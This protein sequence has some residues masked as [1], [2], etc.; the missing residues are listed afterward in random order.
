MA[1]YALMLAAGLA[2]V[3]LAAAACG[4][5]SSDPLAL[6]GYLSQVE[7]LDDQAEQ[8]QNQLEATFQDEYGNE[9]PNAPPSAA[10]LA[11]LRAYYEELVV[12]GREYIN[13]VDD[14]DPPDEAQEAHDEYVASYDEVLVE[15]NDVIDQVEGVTTAGAL[16][17]LLSSGPMTAA[18]ERADEAC[19]GLQSVADEGNFDIDFEC[20]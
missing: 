2:V 12:I 11:G 4:G 7:A 10:F 19:R 5:G 17:D 1:R 20:R 13:D 9:D 6:D 14:L 15:L 8:E 16:D 18:F 3:A